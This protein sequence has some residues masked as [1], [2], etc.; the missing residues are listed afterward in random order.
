M[1][2]IILVHVL[3]GSCG[4]KS[5]DNQFAIGFPGILCS[6]KSKRVHNTSRKGTTRYTGDFSAS[7]R[8]SKM[9][10]TS[11][12][13]SKPERGRSHAICWIYVFMGSI[14]ILQGLHI[15]SARQARI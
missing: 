5:I 6:G 15:T 12:M 11:P 14:C 9:K 7:W 13:R 4:R 8:Y 3:C 1:N 10:P 2:S